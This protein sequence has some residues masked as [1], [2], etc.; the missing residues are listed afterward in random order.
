MDDLT[1]IDGIGPAT[2]KRLAE[3]GFTTFE[4]LAHDGI[5]GEHGIKVEWIAEAAKLLH[6]GDEP[7]T[8]SETNSTDTSQGADQGGA[9]DPAGSAQITFRAEPVIFDGL[10]TA[11]A[12]SAQV[13]ALLS[14]GAE[15]DEQRRVAP[16]LRMANA[17]ARRTFATVSTVIHDGRTVRRGG[18][19]HVT[20][21]EFDQLRAASAIEGRWEDGEEA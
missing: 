9:G 16:E 13:A 11:P 19:I 18:P 2:A 5:A 4:K 10:A 1:K 8:A 3:A 6:A 14:F 12:G 15:I 17:E 20:R 7:S 21:K